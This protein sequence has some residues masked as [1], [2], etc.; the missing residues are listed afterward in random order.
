[1]LWQPA[2]ELAS[3]LLAPGGIFLH[4]DTDKWGG[5]ANVQAV[6]PLATKLGLEHV[7]R[8]EPVQYRGAAAND[9]RFYAM[10]FRKK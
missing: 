6:A 1:M 9:G 7:A 4:Y 10:A 8:E 5:F 3:L 2:L